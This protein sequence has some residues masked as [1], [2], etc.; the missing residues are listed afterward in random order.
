MR[1]LDS[2]GHQETAYGINEQG[3]VVVAASFFCPD[4]CPGSGLPRLRGLFWRGG[5]GAPDELGDLAGGLPES[6]ARDVNGSGTIV[7]FGT[8]EEGRRTVVWGGSGSP[9]SLGDDTLG[10]TGARTKPLVRPRAG[11]P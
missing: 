9:T 1:F 7:G 5:D 2:A 11:A 6:G 4:G 3:D 8:V 10:G